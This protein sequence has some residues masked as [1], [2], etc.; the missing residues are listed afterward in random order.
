MDDVEGGDEP[1]RH[2]QEDGEVVVQELAQRPRHDQHAEADDDEDDLGQRVEEE[3]GMQSR[4][5]QKGEQHDADDRGVAI[6]LRPFV[7]TPVHIVHAAT[8]AKPRRGCRRARRG[9]RAQGYRPKPPR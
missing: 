6:I 9:R 7:A 1:Q 5:V 4:E 3:V 8:V 2:A